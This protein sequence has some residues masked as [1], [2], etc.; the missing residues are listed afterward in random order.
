[1]RQS[2]ARERLRAATPD[3]AVELAR[4]AITTYGRATASMRP[5]PDY[6]VIGA[7]KGGTTSIV[8]WLARHPHVLPMFPRLSRRKSPHY[9][10]INYWQGDAWYRGHFPSEAVRALHARRT[11]VVPLTGEAS[12]YYLF[13][14][15]AAER[16]KQTAPDV[17]LI[18]VLREP[19]SRAFSHYRDRVATGFEELP[20]F[21]QAIAAEPER[22]AGFTD[23]SLRD[24][25]AYNHDHDH[26]TY[27]ARGHYAPQLRRYFDVF[28]RDQVLVLTIDE[29]ARDAA[30]AF[31][32]VQDFLGLPRA[33]MEL[34]PVNV[35]R[36]GPDLPEETAQRLRRHFEPLNA[37]LYELLRTDLGW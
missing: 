8:N 27:L 15:W 37:E 22:L 19:V 31:G 7:K 5:L 1:M 16:I 24:P 30:S 3:R 34:R 23:A 25:R 29:L 35:R 32:K 14:P 36:G 13:H 33:D 26:H 12:P 28:G 11:G 4:T 6:L 21:E 20:T 18:A 9:F 10:D 2:A 17:K